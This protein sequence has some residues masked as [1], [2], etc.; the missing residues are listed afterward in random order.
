MLLILITDLVTVV[1]GVVVVP[2]PTLTT[3]GVVLAELGSCLRAGPVS[4]SPLHL[5]TR[6]HTSMTTRVCSGAG[7]RGLGSCLRAGPVFLRPVLAPP[8]LFRVVPRV[9]PLL[10]A[11]RSRSL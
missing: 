10:L 6:I 11:L 9:N 8:A 5:R 3:L 4:A 1:A 7:W 2:V